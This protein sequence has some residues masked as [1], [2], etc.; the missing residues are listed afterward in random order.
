[1]GF[2]KNPDPYAVAWLD[3]A[4]KLGV[5]ITIE[6]NNYET[7]F[8]ES[9][10]IMDSW[11]KTKYTEVDLQRFQVQAKSLLDDKDV[12]LPAVR[13]YPRTL[14]W[15][16]ERLRNDEN[17]VLDAVTMDPFQLKRA[18][19]RIRGLVRVVKVALKVEPLALESVSAGSDAAN[20][21]ELILEA[22]K[23][24][25]RA[26]RYVAKICPPEIVRDNEIV[27]AAVRNYPSALK[28][29]PDNLK[30]D[31]K[32]VEAA[33]L[34]DGNLLRFARDEIKAN[35]QIALLAVQTTG[36][37][38]Q[39]VAKKLQNDNDLVCIAGCKT[40]EGLKFA[41]EQQREKFEDRFGKL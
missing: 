3:P 18:S 17:L 25:G 11:S 7:K 9:D 33:V 37:A 8:M 24:N 27:L 31:F 28:Y 12:M 5:P 34:Q 16:S 36:E 38:L 15:A 40:R 2:S 26:L 14:K 20:N 35:K 22:M 6:K 1:M 41:S 23:K 32:I 13:R 4:T 21:R 39:F 19:I 29:A 10:E 30:G